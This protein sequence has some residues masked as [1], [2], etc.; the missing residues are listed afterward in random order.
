MPRLSH[1]LKALPGKVP[2][3]LDD[4]LNDAA[5]P[6]PRLRTPNSTVSFG[7]RRSAT[8]RP[9]RRRPRERLSAAVRELIA[10][11]WRP[12]QFPAGKHPVEAYRFFVEP[13]Q[14]LE[15]LAMAYPYLEAGL[16]AEVKQ[17][18]AKLSAEGGPL[19]GP[20]GAR[21]FHAEQGANR[22]AYDVPPKELLRSIGRH[23]RAAN[24]PGSIRSGCGHT[25]RAIGTGSNATG[26]RFKASS[27]AHPT[28]WKRT[29]ATGTWPA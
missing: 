13:T 14:T 12:L 17:Y 18:V 28:R 8:P 5:R 10:Q 25:R 22:A 4:P 27:T 16:Q 7:R 26:R 19:A 9:R 23:H 15:V 29:A 20:T 3:T 11:P 24:W 6:W 1:V 2:G 21:V